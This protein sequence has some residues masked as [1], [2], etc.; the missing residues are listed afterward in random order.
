[1]RAGEKEQGQVGGRVRREEGRR[2][3]V[4]AAADDHLAS[5]E[6]TGQE[7]DGGELV[8][9]LVWVLQNEDTGARGPSRRRREDVA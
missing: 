5:G 1:M 6:A 4:Q 3:G 7:G 8:L 2:I 9:K